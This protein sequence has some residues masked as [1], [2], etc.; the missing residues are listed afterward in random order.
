MASAAVRNNILGAALIILGATT[1]QWS[2]ALVSPAFRL[3]GPSATS[4]WRFLLGSAVLL[5]LT[6][7]KLRQ[8]AWP[9]WRA[10]V[11][12]GL[13]VAFMNQCFFQSLARIPLGSAVT[14]EFMGPLVVAVLGHRSWRHATFAGLAAVG[15]VLLAHP[16][17]HLTLAGTLFGLGSG[18]GWAAYIFAS[19]KVGG[20]T[21][22]FEGLAVSM[23][24]AAVVT[25]PMSLGAVHLVVH[26]P[27]V[28]G[29]LAIVASMSI[30]LGFALEMQALRRIRPAV[31]GVLMAFDPAIAFFL[32]F[33][34]LGQ[35][36][37]AWV[38]VGLVCVVCA[39]VGVTIDQRDAAPVLSTAP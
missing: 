7:P 2:A 1:I 10:A 11:V 3:V 13:S 14:I 39:G 33:V 22:G 27:F 34:V 25:L 28:L 6:R 31:V 21:K 24:V 30:V 15:V 23:A 16:G 9:Q 38:L 36:P 19:A 26:H 12:L 5:V 29:R 32:G 8:W 20:A 17:G 18:L 4:A 37:T 35:R